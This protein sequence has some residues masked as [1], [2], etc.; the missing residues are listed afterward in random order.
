[1]LVRGMGKVVVCWWIAIV[2]MLV[3]GRGELS[4]A[5]EKPKYG[6]FQFRNHGAGRGAAGERK[7][8]AV[9]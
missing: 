4:Y 5:G 3:R 6:S 8:A 2:V 9:V 7:G 1:M